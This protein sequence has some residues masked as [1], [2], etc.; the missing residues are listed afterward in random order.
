[1]RVVGQYSPEMTTSQSQPPAPQSLSFSEPKGS[2]PW[3]PPLPGTSS[4]TRQIRSPNQ[5]VQ[6]GEED[7]IAGNRETGPILVVRG[8]T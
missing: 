8:P 5:A 6:L 4:R 2:L 7:A 3:V 1:M